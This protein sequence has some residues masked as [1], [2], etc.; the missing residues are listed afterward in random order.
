MATQRFEHRSVSEWVYANAPTAPVHPGYTPV[1]IF[2]DRKPKGV[3]TLLV[4]NGGKI[5][6]TAS[7]IFRF[8]SGYG[9]WT[10]RTPHDLIPRMYPIENAVQLGD[11]DIA[12]C[13]T[14]TE[15]Y[16]PYFRG[17]SLGDE[18]ALCAEKLSRAS[19]A[20]GHGQRFTSL[21][22]GEIYICLGIRVLGDESL[23]VIKKNNTTPGES[24]SGYI[25]DT[26]KLYVLSMGLSSA[27]NV[28]ST[29]AIILPI[30]DFQT[31]T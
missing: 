25:D 5:V 8:S 7:H 17:H 10:Y 12:V 18:E 26:G 14:P 22:T 30:P 27:P 4:R 3:G 1:A 13:A 29:A 21:V 6:I 28:P 19:V 2:H 16:C 15:I 11:L 20:L 23:Y 9:Y 31:A 24:G